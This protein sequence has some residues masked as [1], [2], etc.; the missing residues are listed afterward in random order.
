M[1]CRRTKANVRQAMRIRLIIILI[2]AA[3][4]AAGCGGGDGGGGNGPDTTP[5]EITGGPN[6]IDIDYQGASIEWTTDELATSVVYFGKT[7][8]YGDSVVS[9]AYVRNHSLAITGREPVTLYHYEVHS[10][11]E[12]GNRVSS[13][14]YFFTTSSP[15][16]KFVEE[17]WD[18][19]EDGQYDSSLSRFD[20][21]AVYDP[22]NVD[23]LEGRGWSYLRLSNL[24]GRDVGA[25]LESA[26]A[27]LEDA[28]DAEPGRVDCLVAATFVYQAL[29]EHEQAI[30]SGNE[31]LLL[32]G[33]VYAFPH[34]WEI[35]G[36][37]VRYSLILSLAATG[38]FRGAL[39]VARVID[40]TIEIDPDDPGSWGVHSTF[41]EAM[42][43]LIEDLR[44][45][46]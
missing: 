3:A 40:N 33:G 41:E 14:D 12:S 15:A 16:D 26:R 18:F 36:D 11:D 38:D 42:I 27:A 44:D 5:P 9:T 39:E 31:V 23:V 28:L 17:G 19:F 32:T 10:S 21:A 37:D 34:D 6:A 45:R 7:V 22:G 1:H 35:T 25:M 20:A 30:G 24:P 29:E 2:L 43:A 13:A 4:V 8:Q 46:V